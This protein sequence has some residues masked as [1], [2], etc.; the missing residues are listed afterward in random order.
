MV[1]ECPAALELEVGE[2]CWALVSGDGEQ[3]M[4]VR[5]CMSC[6]ISAGFGWQTPSCISGVSEDVEPGL[7]CGDRGRWGLQGHLR[8]GSDCHSQGSLCQCGT[9]A[10]QL[11]TPESNDDSKGSVLHNLE[12]ILADL[13]RPIVP[14]RAGTG[15]AVLLPALLSVHGWDARILLCLSFPASKGGGRE[16]PSA[17]QGLANTS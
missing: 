16:H 5:S 4:R 8:P 6:G 11:L 7:G 10:L 12:E 14:C 13:K 1:T 17:W 9:A 3:G 2:L 15:V